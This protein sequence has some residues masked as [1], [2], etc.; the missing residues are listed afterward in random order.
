M[1]TLYGFA[2]P[3]HRLQRRR[4]PFPEAARLPL[5]LLRLGLRRVGGGERQVRRDVRVEEAA[6]ALRRRE[7]PAVVPRVL[8]EVEA[9]RLVERA[10]AEVVLRGGRKG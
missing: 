10:Y 6:R 4:L 1:R 2:L 5:P 9:P 3:K 8:G 7:H